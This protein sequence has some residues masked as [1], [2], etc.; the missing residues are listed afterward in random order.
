MRSRKVL[1]IG[2][3]LVGVVTSIGLAYVSSDTGVVA[4]GDTDPPH[5]VS[6]QVQPAFV[7]TSLGDQ[8]LT[9]TMH[10]TDNLS[11]LKA[12]FTSL[13]WA[14]Y[15]TDGSHA[16]PVFFTYPETLISGN[17][18]NGTFRG[19]A[20]LPQFSAQGRWYIW[21]VSL[22]DNANNHCFWRRPPDT[23]Q[24]PECAPKSALPYFVN[25]ADNGPPASPTP[26]PTDTPT[27]TPTATSTSTD[28]PT[29]TSTDTPTF[30][31]T[32]TPSETPTPTPTLTPDLIA[33]QTAISNQIAT[34]VA[35]TLTALASQPIEGTGTPDINATETAV[36][37]QVATAV[38]A[39]LTALAPQ[40][41]EG[42]GTP[43]ANQLSL[44]SIIR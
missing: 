15:S 24:D 43:P 30:T 40:A 23:I 28:T 13:A 9:I 5:L 16:D 31:P 6:L 26:T 38:A 20:K 25:G 21:Q 22:Y 34:A 29:A 41:T 11:G 2:V 32:N 35:A 10:V 37:N 8:T 39:T 3:L 33:T 14:R 1:A 18:L 12:S 4:Q 7:D 42:T 27:D 17:A 44:P 19:T 36:A